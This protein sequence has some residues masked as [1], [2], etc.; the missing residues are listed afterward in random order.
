MEGKQ[1]HERCEAGKGGSSLN[2][3]DVLIQLT[4]QDREISHIQKR[5]ER[6]ESQVEAINKLTLSVNNLAISVREML[7]VQKSQGSRL[8]RLER[9]PAERVMGIRREIVRALISALAGTLLGALVAYFS[10]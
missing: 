6:L 5:M 10:K 8:S 7:Q 1:R 9:M 3:E 2:Q 4:A